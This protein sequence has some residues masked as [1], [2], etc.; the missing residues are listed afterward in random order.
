MDGVERAWLAAQSLVEERPSA[1]VLSDLAG[2]ESQSGEERWFVA[3][4]RSHRFVELEHDEP[5]ARSA[6]EEEVA[7]KARQDEKIFGHLAEMSAGNLFCVGGAGCQRQEG[8]DM[9]SLPCMDL[10]TLASSCEPRPISD[11]VSERERLA[12]NVGQDERRLEGERAV[13]QLG[14]SIEGMQNTV[15]CRAIELRRL[16]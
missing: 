8:V 2:R 15:L 13:E 7:R 9:P 16:R 5:L 1:V 14:D 11:A 6:A 4:L 10:L 3:E 12:R